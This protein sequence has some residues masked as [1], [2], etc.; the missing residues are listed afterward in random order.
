MASGPR[1]KAI[2]LFALR[3]TNASPIL[4]LNCA[5]RAPWCGIECCCYDDSSDVRGCPD[6][7]KPHP[8]HR[9][10]AISMS[11][12]LAVSITGRLSILGPGACA[13]RTPR[14]AANGQL[15]WQDLWQDRI[16]EPQ[17]HAA[18]RC[19]AVYPELRL[20]PPTLKDRGTAPC[21]RG[22]CRWAGCRHE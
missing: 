17:S 20:S 6:V 4:C 14:S 2:P 18:H 15:A 1:H 16:S 5:A 22:A 7:T 13:L 11:R 10:Q 19:S 9:P 21:A 12:P 3:Y 8:W